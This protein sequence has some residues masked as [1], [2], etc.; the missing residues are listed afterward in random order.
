MTVNLG[1]LGG[2]VFEPRAGEFIDA[3]P[4]GE[5]EE[6]VLGVLREMREH[7]AGAFRGAHAGERTMGLELHARIDVREERRDQADI[8]RAPGAEGFTEFAQSD[9][10][11]RRVLALQEFGEV[12]G[13]GGAAAEQPG[14]V[15]AGDVV[16]GPILEG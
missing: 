1:R 9:L 16:R 10:D 15:T 3:R 13:V 2:D 8:R 6:G 4:G 7:G 11:A 5:I 14:S 12:C